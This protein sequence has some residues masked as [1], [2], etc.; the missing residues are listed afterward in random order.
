MPTMTKEIY[1]KKIIKSFNDCKKIIKEGKR[2]PVIDTGKEKRTKL[3]LPAF[4]DFP[5]LKIASISE[6]EYSHSAYIH[7]A[8]VNVLFYLVCIYLRLDKN[9]VGKYRKYRT[10]DKT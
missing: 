5:N 1:L 3:E 7:L 6:N 2:T 10:S 8:G 9:K 4:G